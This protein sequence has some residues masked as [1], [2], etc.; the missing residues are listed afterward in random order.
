[1]TLWMAGVG[2]RLDWFVIR[3]GHSPSPFQGA[4]QG[5]TAPAISLVLLTRDLFSR[6]GVTLCT[7]N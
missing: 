1:M 5:T 6:P 4:R 7:A 2:K 3:V